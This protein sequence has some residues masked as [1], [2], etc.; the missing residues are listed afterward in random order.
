MK[1]WIHD[2]KITNNDNDTAA[3]C[4]ANKGIIPFKEL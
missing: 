1:K 2:P 4:F 3:M